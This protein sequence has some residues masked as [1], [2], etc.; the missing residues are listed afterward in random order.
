MGIAPRDCPVDFLV[1]NNLPSPPFHDILGS[2]PV[3]LRATWPEF[4]SGGVKRHSN[5]LYCFVFKCQNLAG[6][7]YLEDANHLD[8]IQ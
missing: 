8:E 3:Y 5:P 4:L 2:M 1:I 7:Y 6:T